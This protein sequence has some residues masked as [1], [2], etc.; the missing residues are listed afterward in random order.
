MILKDMKQRSP[1]ELSE[2]LLRQ[3]DVLRQHGQ[4]VA[5]L[6]SRIASYEQQFNVPSSQIHEAIDT[7]RLDESVE[8]CDWIMDVELLERART[9]SSA[10]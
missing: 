5:A 10:R 8:V 2:E 3:I 9:H 6:E 4:H 7:G 1:E